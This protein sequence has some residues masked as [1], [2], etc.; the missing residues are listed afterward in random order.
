[1]DRRRFEFVLC[2]SGA[3]LFGIAGEEAKAVSLGDLSNREVDQG[4]KAALEQGA[5]AAVGLLGRPD[6][7]LSNPK[8]RIPLPGFLK[9]AAQLLKAM[10]RGKQVDELEVAMNRAAEAAVPL[11][12][13]MLVRAAKSITLNDARGILTGG[14]TSVTDFFAGRTR[15]PL[16][17]KFLPVVTSATRN[18]GLAQKYNAVAGKVARTGLVRKE[19]ANIEQYVT[20]KSLDG[21]YYVIGQEERKIRANPAQAGSAVLRRV[22]GALQ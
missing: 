4:L 14:E 1:M 13:D 6:G 16:Q 3:L 18:V 2:A 21:L 5:L 10:G 22:F 20:G 9:D 8:V 11:A 7:F 12:R 19:D 17:I 15:E